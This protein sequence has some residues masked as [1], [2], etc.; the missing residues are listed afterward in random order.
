MTGDYVLEP[1]A[2]L[3][4]Y[5]EGA[6][7]DRDLG[8]ST[9]GGAFLAAGIL[10]FVVFAIGAGAL[11]LLPRVAARDGGLA[12]TAPGTLA[13]RLGGYL[14]VALAPVLLVLLGWR[15]ANP[16]AGRRARGVP[17]S[18]VASRA[19]G[20]FT[21]VLIG[22]RVRRRMRVQDREPLDPRDPAV[23]GPAVAG[24][25]GPLRVWAREGASDPAVAAA[26]ARLD[27]PAGA[28]E[29]P[30]ARAR[31]DLAALRAALVERSAGEGEG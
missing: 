30:L 14:A 16:D 26:L 7:Y 31:G 29:D 1:E 27:A 23:L 15:L 10:D 28:G 13:L 12:H 6:G 11:I 24:A 17:G 18:G 4:A 2:L 8:A 22:A 19:Y 3:R 20:L 5:R 9:E 25:A 21:G